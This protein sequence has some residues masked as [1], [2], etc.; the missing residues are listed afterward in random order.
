M[1]EKMAYIDSNDGKIYTLYTSEIWVNFDSYEFD[2][3]LEPLSVKL[4]IGDHEVASTDETF[5]VDVMHN[6]YEKGL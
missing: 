4:F 3:A 6:F 1:S 5:L 2:D